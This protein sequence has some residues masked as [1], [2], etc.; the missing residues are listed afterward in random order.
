MLGRDLRDEMDDGIDTMMCMLTKHVVC[1]GSLCFVLL[2]LDTW[3]V[4]LWT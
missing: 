3:R 1:H 4:E 2:V